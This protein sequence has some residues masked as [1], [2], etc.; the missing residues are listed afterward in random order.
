MV[1]I[2]AILFSICVFPVH[3]VC[4]AYATT[5]EKYASINVTAFRL[6]T[7]INKNTDMLKD[8]SLKRYIGE[9]GDD[10][11]KGKIITP[12]NWLKLFNKLCIVKIVQLCDYGIRDPQNV[13]AALA[14]STITDIAYA[15]IRI[16]GGKTKLSYQTVLNYEHSD[17]N[18]YLKLT[19]IINVFTILKMLAIFLWGKLNERKIKKTAKGR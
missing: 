9:S 13:Y 16:N 2:S 7:V 4:Y 5:A 19:G 6:F 15:F 3:V 17:I 10:D 8:F 12:E 1:Y 18:Y 11:K 14:G